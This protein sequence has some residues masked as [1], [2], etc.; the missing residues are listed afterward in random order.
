MAMGEEVDLAEGLPETM[1]EVPTET[2]P[3][4]VL[5]A[6]RMQV[7]WEALA[8]QLTLAVVGK[9]VPVPVKVA[10]EDADTMVEEVGG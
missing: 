10:E 7:E 5:E 8:S 9:E 1:E 3:E 2:E 4:V 6:A